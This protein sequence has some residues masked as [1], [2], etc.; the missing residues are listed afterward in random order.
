V[1]VPTPHIP[2]VTEGVVREV[3]L[4]GRIVTVDGKCRSV[5]FAVSPG[6]EVLLNGERVKL[7]MLQ[8]RDRVRVAYRDGGGVPAAL[9]VEARSRF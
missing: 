8:P 4:I 7:R 6:C 9:S 2:K 5:A 1:R 3:D